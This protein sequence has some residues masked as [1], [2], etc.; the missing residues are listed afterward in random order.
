MSQLTPQQ[1]RFVEEYLVDLN[2]GQAAKRAGYSDT[3][4]SHYQQAA[5]LLRNVNIS[6]AVDKAL[7]ARGERL[8]VKADRV[9]KE[10]LRIAFA[11]SRR[12]M[13]WDDER[14]LVFEPSDSLDDDTAAAIS[15]VSEK[16]TETK[17]GIKR[18]QRVKM[19]DKIRALELL[20]KH[21]GMWKADQGDGQNP[22]AQFL[23]LLGSGQIDMNQVV[24]HLAGKKP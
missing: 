3:N 17:K 5:R 4:G 14:G 20:G 16:V 23:Q 1:Q 18:E 2:G 12:T 7:A 21:L 15:E 24:E 22:M 19:H 6:E 13:R 10:L 9:V 8:G 11:D